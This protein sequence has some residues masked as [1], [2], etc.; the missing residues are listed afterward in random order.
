MII[1]EFLSFTL[2][3]Y[4]SKVGSG[5]QASHNACGSLCDEIVTLWKLAALN[6]RISPSERPLLKKK[7]M[8]YHVAVIEK[9]MVSAF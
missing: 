5:S 9:I 8:E 7:L 1:T 4:I 2:K 3:A 6:P